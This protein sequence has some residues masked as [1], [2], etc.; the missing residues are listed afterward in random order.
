MTPNPWLGRRVIAF[1]HQGGAWEWPSSTLFA[2]RRAIEAGATA[3]ELDVHATKDGELVVCHDATI[4][5]TTNGSGAIAEL[6]HAEIRTLD[7]AYWFIPGS[8]VAPGRDPGDYPYRGRAPDDPDFRVATLREVLEEF[9]GVVLNLDIKQTAPAVAPY[10]EPLARLLAEYERED[11]VIVASFL[12]DA[13]ARFAGLAPHVAISA[14]TLAVTAFWRAL[15]QGDEAPETDAVAFQVPERV[16]ETV[17]V[18]RRFLDAAH[19]AGKAVHV[20]TIDDEA[21][22]ERLVDLGVDGIVTD[23]PSVLCAV[24]ERRGV[25]W[26]RG[27]S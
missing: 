11:D 27:R 15:N 20:W 14:G 6:T 24:L 3:I 8:D 22:M 17:V 25:A 13:T 7:N 4:D 1:A 21:S 5:R 19:G 9:P 23:L 12:D 2:I 16:G 18:D 10:E 26:G